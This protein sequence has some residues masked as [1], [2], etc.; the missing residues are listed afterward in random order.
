MPLVT[1]G[2][3]TDNSIAIF[4]ID[5]ATR[6]LASVAARTIT[7][8]ATYGSCMYHSPITGKFYYFVDSKAGEIEQWELFDNGAGLVDAT[9]IRN[10][11][12]LDTQ[13]EACVVDD[14][15]GFFYIGEEDV[16]IWKFAAE[17]TVDPSSPYANGVLVDSTG[18]GGHL[19]ADVEGLAL[20]R[21]GAGTGYLIAANQGDSTYAIYTREGSNTF[22][23]MFRVG[24]GAACIDEVTGSDGIDAT[25]TPL[26]PAFAGGVL[27]TQDDTN[28]PS[29]NQNFKLVPLPDILGGPVG[30]EPACVPGGGTGG[31]GGST[32]A[33]G[34][35]GA[36]GSTGTGGTGGAGFP[37]EFCQRFCGKCDSCWHAGV[38]FDDGDCLYML[39][40]PNFGLDDCM[41]G[42]A[43]GR[44][45]GFPPANLA[46]DWESLS[47]P[48]WDDSM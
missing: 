5:P 38:G 8:L 30:P 29:G 22:V 43:I 39:A 48:A 40:K 3:R 13:P 27:V 28:G 20:A 36:G 17:P 25:T 33:G 7:T 45:P 12:K 10:L 31:A 46:P 6:V 42:C 21:T 41:A 23:K 16:G 47:C 44:T 26:G 34:M 1:A 18:P 19:V 24:S 37:L 35:S 32:G 14:E 4:K 9:K 2:N 15:L 11:R